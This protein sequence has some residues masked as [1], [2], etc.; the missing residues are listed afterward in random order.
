LSGSPDPKRADGEGNE[1]NIKSLWIKKKV[2]GYAGLLKLFALYP[3]G[4]RRDS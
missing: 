3:K 4:L 1:R 2:K